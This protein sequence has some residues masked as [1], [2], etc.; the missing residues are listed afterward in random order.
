MSWL[1]NLMSYC[2]TGDAGKCPTCGSAQISVEEHVLGKRKSLS[3]SCE[4]CK[5][6]DH[7]D[8]I[9]EENR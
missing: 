5:A 8:G 4:E 9:N 6:G 2:K 3:F 1:N 7:F